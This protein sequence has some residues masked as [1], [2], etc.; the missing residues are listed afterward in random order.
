MEGFIF[1]ICFMNHSKVSSVKSRSWEMDDG[2]QDGLGIW[3][4]NFPTS[5][6]SERGTQIGTRKWGEKGKKVTI[7]S[8]FEIGG[9]SKFLKFGRT[10]T[11]R[12]L[13][14]HSLKEI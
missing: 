7:G 13:D 10:W 12:C 4:A 5:K 11:C 6:F 14:S 3:F 9:V 8:S 2:W 1:T